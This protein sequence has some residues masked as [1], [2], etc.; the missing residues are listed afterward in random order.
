V[1]LPHAW[2]DDGRAA[3]DCIGDG[4]TMLRLGHSK[5][6]M[7]ALE[8]AFHGH[9]APFTVL[10]LTGAAARDIYGYDLILVRPDLHVVWRGNAPPE[11]PA[12]LAALA[13]GHTS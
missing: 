6:D 11:N 2:L 4:Y 13:T 12:A 3:Q 5:T 10:D 8:S 7:S 9:G 1:R